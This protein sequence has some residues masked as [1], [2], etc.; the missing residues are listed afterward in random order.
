M[1][2]FSQRHFHINT[3]YYG[4]YTKYGWQLNDWGFG[5]NKKRIDK[6][7]KENAT[8]YVSYLKSSRL[9]TIKAE[10]VQKYPIDKIG[11]ASVEVY[12][13]PRSSL[14]YCDRTREDIKLKELCQSGIFG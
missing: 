12:I 5:L 6:L 14:N 11:W 4:A 1:L 3:P 9:Y 8:I 10:A 2:T 7:A 13:I